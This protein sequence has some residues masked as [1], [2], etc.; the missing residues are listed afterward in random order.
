MA[1]T[2]ALRDTE[3]APGEKID[4][5]FIHHDHIGHGS[6]P[7]AWALSLTLIVGSIIAGLGMVLEVWVL[8]WISILFLPLAIILGLVLKAKGYGVEMDSTAVLKNGESARAHQGPASPDN[9]R[10]GKDKRRPETAAR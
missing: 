6:T 8:V 5:E 1:N 7:A 10:G 4:D 9:T 3:P 2:N